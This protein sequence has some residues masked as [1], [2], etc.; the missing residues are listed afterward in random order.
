VPRQCPHG[1]HLSQ[2]TQSPLVDSSLSKRPDAQRSITVDSLT[3]RVSVPLLPTGWRVWWWVV[4]VAPRARGICDSRK[5]GQ[6]VSLTGSD[7]PAATTTERKTHTL[8]LCT[9]ALTVALELASVSAVPAFASRKKLTSP[10]HPT[11]HTCT[12]WAHLTL[13]QPRRDARLLQRLVSSC[14]EK[15][16]V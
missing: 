13:R 6:C 9:L 2:I 10:P 1:L 5:Y 16:C 4:C 11:T 3:G 7:C 12:P 15:W 14:L 8:F